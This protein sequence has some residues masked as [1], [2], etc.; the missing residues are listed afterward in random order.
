MATKLKRVTN[1]IE[2]FNDTVPTTEKVDEILTAFSFTYRR[3][4][5][6]TQVQ[7]ASEFIKQLRQYTR[8]I[9]KDYKHSTAIKQL[10][11]NS[12]FDIDLGD[13]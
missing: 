9:V 11:D 4:E 2:A 5:E 6:L 3:N 13:D 12:N 1:I 10:I 7:Q 8:Q